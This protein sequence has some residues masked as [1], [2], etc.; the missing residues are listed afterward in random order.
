MIISGPE[1]TR[2]EPLD[3][4]G[5][6]LGRDQNC[7][8]V[9]DNSSVSRLHARIFRDPFG[10][11]IIEDMKSH[12]GVLVDGKQIKAQAL[13]PGQKVIIHPFTL[14]LS[15]EFEQKQV[16]DSPMQKSVSVID[17]GFEE[18]VVSYQA[19][20]DRTLSAALLRRL[21]TIS[22]DLLQLQSSSELYSQASTYLADMLNALVAFVR[23]PSASEPLPPSPQVLSCNFGGRALKWDSSK[24]SNIHLSKRVLDAVRSAQSPVMARSGPSSDKKLVLTVVDEVTPHVVFSAPINE[25]LG[26]VDAI[27]IDILEERMPH[28]MFDFVE[29]VARQISSVQKTMIYSEA[30]AEMMVLEK[31]LELARGIQS[32]LNPEK[33]QDKFAVDVAVV[34]KPSMWVGG[35]Y[36]DVWTL[37]N[38]Q[39]AFAVGDVSG[40]GL[41]AA[42]IMS[43]LQ[44]ALRTTMSFCS[45][46]STVAEHINRHLCQNLRDDM[47]VTFFLGLFDPST[48]KLS[49]INAGHLPPLVVSRSEPARQLE[50]ASNIPL[51]IFEGSFETATEKI[52]P[53]ARLLVFTD[54]IT[55]ASNPDD[56]MFEI[57]LLQ[58]LVTESA[59]ESAQ[60]LVNQIVDAV[61]DFR[62]HLP[63]QDDITVFALVNRKTNPSPTTPTS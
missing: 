26:K 63:Q 39:I 44:A 28:E 57:E 35:D 61:S 17:K 19:G 27:Y 22:S 4:Q 24:T 47:F 38:G 16:P 32:K 58:K 31:Q 51:G 7:D 53:D 6:T 37:D 20:T 56:K 59:A 41:P 2:Q 50:Q 60:E 12:N 54:G 43:N 25:S 1:G 55:E 14:T 48:E 30:K 10:R 49:Y 15:Q 18:E 62:Q 33:L 13:L 23:L 3:P 21:N 5:A 29:A 8:I 52:N 46:L 36:Y 9:L 40:K 34:Y 11:W 45:D 42:M